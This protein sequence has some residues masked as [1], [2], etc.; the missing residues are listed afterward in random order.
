MA[1]IVNTFEVAPDR[2][3]TLPTIPLVD[4]RLGFILRAE[5]DGELVETTLTIGPAE[6]AGVAGYTA[7]MLQRDLDAAR[8]KLAEE[9]EWRA[10]VRKMMEGV[11]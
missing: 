10:R 5:I 2:A 1:E 11:S 8:Q 9:A 3:V 6:G 7:E 4:G